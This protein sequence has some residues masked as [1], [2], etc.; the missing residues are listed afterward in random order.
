LHQRRPS[1]DDP[2]G[3]VCP[4]GLRYLGLGLIRDPC[5]HGR[6]RPPVTCTLSIENRPCE[7][8]SSRPVIMLY[9]SGRVRRQGSPRGS[10]RL[11][12]N[13]YCQT[14]RCAVPHRPIALRPMPQPASTKLI[15]CQSS[16]LMCGVQRI[17][18]IRSRSAQVS[19]RRSRAWP[20]RPSTPIM[21]LGMSL[22]FFA[23]ASAVTSI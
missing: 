10:K 1:P 17:C 14:T 19:R 15:R 16:G 5:A 8:R 22:L 20:D 6:T 12:V 11:M 23:P 7:Q 9:S 13:G 21:A 18:P 4:K 3:F 2:P